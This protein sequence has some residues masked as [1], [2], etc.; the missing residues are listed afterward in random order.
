MQE[1]EDLFESVKLDE[2]GGTYKY[3]QIRLKEETTEKELILIRGWHT[4]HYHKDIFDKFKN[5]EYRKHPSVQNYKIR[6]DCPGGG[7]IQWDKENKKITLMSFSASFGK[8][9]HSLSKEIIL[10]AFPD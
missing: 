9:D 8:C 6:A 10:K 7:K 4:C 5:E 3:I 1:F 2:R